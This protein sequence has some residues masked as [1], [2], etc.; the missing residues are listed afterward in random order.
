M[1][2]MINAIN[3]SDG[4]DGLAGGES[5]LSLGCI[6]W[7]SYLAHGTAVS[8]IALA[9]IGGLFGFMR[10]NT[11]PARIFMGDGGSQY[12]GFTLG[13]LVVL[14]TQQVNPVLSPAL[15]ALILGLPVADIIVV[16]A[17]RIYHRMNWFRA[18]RNHIHHRLLDLGFYHHESVMIVYSLQAL[19]VLCAVGMPYESDALI[20]GIYLAVVTTLFVSLYVAERRGWRIHAGN[21]EARADAAVESTRHGQWATAASYRLVYYGISVF[22]MTGV[23]VATK[24]P[25][26]FTVAGI[27]LFVLLLFRLL[28]GYRMW[29]LP[30]R[31]LLY[32][33]I[34]FVV[35]LG[36]TY[37]PSFLVG[38]DPLTYL[39]FGVLTA[40]IGFLI[41]MSGEAGF[42]ITPMDYLVVLVILGL[43]LLARAGVVDAGMMAFILKSA[44][45]FYGCEL[46]LARMERR[47]N[48]FTVSVLISLLVIG[49]RGLILNV[50]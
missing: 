43:A 28:L 35:Y 25:I 45:L 30:L 18:T 13:Y 11:Y 42:N 15:P 12:L 48:V 9:T 40:S 24:V 31:L 47:W 27:V 2:G 19:L 50:L 10:F 3:H 20:A 33:T 38:A 39:F 14:L 8:L 17:Q 32:T 44:I 41:R 36:N 4:L 34:V 23:L 22:L 46:I 29:H 5:L 26:D 21:G 7:L 37:Q 49:V 6:V 1:V 16:L